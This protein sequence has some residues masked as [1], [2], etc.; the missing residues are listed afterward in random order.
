LV[1]LGFIVGSY[2][3][4]ANLVQSPS[5]RH[6]EAEGGMSA[7]EKLMAGALAGAALGAWAS[8]GGIRCRQL[9]ETETFVRFEVLVMKPP[10]ESP[11]PRSE[12]GK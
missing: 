2:R 10:K 6:P 1:C 9:E 4:V 5:H 12:E 11:A 3:E 7:V 8:V